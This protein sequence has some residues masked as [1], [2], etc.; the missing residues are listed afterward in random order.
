[1]PSDPIADKPLYPSDNQYG[2]PNLRY[3]PLTVVPDWLVGEQ[4]VIRQAKGS[5][6]NLTAMVERA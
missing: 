1:M 5:D 2:I 4:V 6:G 3:T